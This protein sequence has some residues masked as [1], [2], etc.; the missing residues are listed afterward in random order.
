MSPSNLDAALRQRAEETADAIMR[1]ARADADRI[2]AD[3]ERT[4]EERRTEVLGGREHVYRSEARA[5]IAAERHEAMRAVLLAK[6][7]VVERVL[8]RARGLLSESAAS[9][10]YRAGLEEELTRALDFVGNEKTIVHCLE[11][12]APALR[13][14]LRSKPD[15]NVEVA[16]DVGTG[17]VAIGVDGR[18]RV[19]STL[20]TRLER[21]APT[22]S[23]EIH[24]RL[25]E[26]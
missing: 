15:A 4:V 7:R 26:R 8:D 2:L 16:D 23:I 21:L 12:L 5:G 24:D 3:A 13:Q 18:V 11:S 19:D 1:A 20:E 25:E 6:T 10:A 17:F 9:E 14:A 22:L